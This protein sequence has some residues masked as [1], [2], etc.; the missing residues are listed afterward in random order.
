MAKNV[1]V[2]IT[3]LTPAGRRVSTAPL[4]E[5]VEM[6]GREARVAWF[7]ATLNL[8]RDVFG[9]W[10]GRAWLV[11]EPLLQAGTYY[12]L[13]KYIFNLSGA[14]VSFATFF[15]AATFWRS[16][17]TLAIGSCNLLVES[18]RYAG[19]DISLRIPYLEFLFSELLNF[20]IRFAVLIVFLRISGYHGS[21]GHVYLLYIAAAQ[22]AFSFSLGVWLSVVGGFLRDLSRIVGHVVWLWW[23]FSPGLYSIGQVPDEIRW[24]YDLNPFA[25]IMPALI[26]A[27]T[28]GSVSG[29]D[30]IT[31]IFFVSLLL[32]I[33][34][35]MLASQVKHRVF[36][37]V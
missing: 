23:F 33:P 2:P 37:R 18:A 36:F 25:H 4:R 22:F 10:L 12:V 24:A 19:S 32:V 27:A 3:T 20:L 6:V 26:E 5:Q 28:V 16:H 9:L 13:L 1:A 29:V 30:T 34:G 17:A 21:I 8:K 11:L 15:T 31:N 7:L 35:G 14:S